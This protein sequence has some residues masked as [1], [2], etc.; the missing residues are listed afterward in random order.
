MEGLST[1]GKITS[2]QF[3]HNRRDLMICDHF[4]LWQIEM[5]HCEWQRA[6]YSPTRTNG[7]I[8]KWIGKGGTRIGDGCRIAIGICRSEV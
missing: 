2:F 8:G 5:V 3:D 1:N 4:Q 7:T 6:G